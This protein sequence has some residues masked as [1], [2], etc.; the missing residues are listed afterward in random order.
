MTVTVTQV[1]TYTVVRLYTQRHCPRYDLGV[2]N[3]ICPVHYSDLSKLFSAKAVV[4]CIMRR[5]IMCMYAGLHKAERVLV[6]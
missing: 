5:A 6:P 4:G 1:Y 3:S 2:H